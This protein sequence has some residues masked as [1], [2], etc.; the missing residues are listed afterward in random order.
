MITELQ[1]YNL[2][3]PQSECIA[4]VPLLH[5][6]TQNLTPLKQEGHKFRDIYGQ[7]IAL[8]T[9]KSRYASIVSGQGLCAPSIE[10]LSIGAKLLVHCIQPIYTPHVNGETVVSFAR[11][12][13]P[14]S[15][16]LINNE[17]SHPLPLTTTMPHRSV[18]IPQGGTGYLSYCP[19]LEMT[20]T[21]FEMKTFEDQESLVSWTLHLEEV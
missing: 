14:G 9:V 7:H 16:F 1:L 19:V 10:A 20:L 11:P 15:V 4:L 5:K 17:N 18:I 13:V 6:C 2:N 12:C 3:T 8:G 21:H